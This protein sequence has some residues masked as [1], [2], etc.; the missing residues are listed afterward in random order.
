MLP[1]NVSHSSPFSGVRA[2]VA[3]QNAQIRTHLRDQ[4]LL[5]GI[6]SVATA[7]SARDLLRQLQS[8][9]TFDIVLCDHHLDPVR[10]GHKLLE[11]IRFLKI[12]PLSSMFIVVTGENHKPQVVSTLEFAPDDYLL[13]PFT[14]DQLTRRLLTL[15]TKK[16]ALQT[17]Y[18]HLANEAWD[19]LIEE[20]DWLIAQRSY[21]L[22]AARLKA[23]ALVVLKR[24]EE[25]LVVYRSLQQEN[26]IPWAR[27]GVAHALMQ[28]EKY[29]EARDDLLDLVEQLPHFMTAYDVLAEACEKLGDIEGA[30]AAIERAATVARQSVPRL[31]RMR[32]LAIT[33]GNKALEIEALR[34]LIERTGNTALSK[35]QHYLSLMR[36][37]TEEQKHQDAEQVLGELK[38]D[39]GKSEKGKLAIV[40]GQA[41]MALARQETSRF[42]CFIGS[43]KIML[44]AHDGLSMEEE[45]LLQ[46]MHIG[47]QTG[48]TELL[49]QVA[50][51]AEGVLTLDTLAA[52][53]SIL[54]PPAKQPSAE[55]PPRP[56]AVVEASPVVPVEAPPPPPI[57]EVAQ[58]PLAEPASAPDVM[59][60][61]TPEAAPVLAQDAAAEAAAPAAAVSPEEL[62]AQWAELLEALRNPASPE[63]M[64]ATEQECREALHALFDAAP[65]DR[66]V[67]RA[68][69]QFDNWATQHGKE[70][71]QPRQ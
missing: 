29:G 9:E 40:T 66:R 60:E 3:D 4:L 16:I 56:P 31:E 68:H 50:A 57:E 53:N 67:V 34:L 27:L 6:S 61:A 13:K 39:H 14:P 59:P 38:T 45:T 37:L 17:L 55:E 2:L 42:E 19:E 5:V 32:K 46:L 21:A 43:A 65:S 48:D 41:G 28:Q 69:V 11:E 36:H 70:K 20:A 35:T 1:P 24:P 51:R 33:G 8:S 62:L 52:L 54:L 44:A 23:E 71:N 7:H 63:A 12:L 30:M 26:I 58:P 49:Q 64:A 25:A 47:Q 22:D 18:Q 15:R 10:D